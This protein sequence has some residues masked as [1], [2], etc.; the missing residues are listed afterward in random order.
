MLINQ[1]EE[2]LLVL[3]ETSLQNSL[4]LFNDDSITFD[5]VI[6]CLIT[7]CKHSAIQAEQCAIIVHTKGKCEVKKGTFDHLSEIKK[8][9]DSNSLTTEIQ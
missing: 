7:Y 3:D 4:I 2:D 9:L 8:S 5:H 6:N 1:D